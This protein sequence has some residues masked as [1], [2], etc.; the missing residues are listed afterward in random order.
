M[1]IGQDGSV[2][3]ASSPLP[4]SFT[5]GYVHEARSETDEFE[6]LLLADFCRC[7][8]TA[9]GQQRPILLSM[10]FMLVLP[11]TWRTHHAQYHVPIEKALE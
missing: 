2:F 4:L 1:A 3:Q 10:R 6:W 5:T 9:L 8:K 7:R 11:N